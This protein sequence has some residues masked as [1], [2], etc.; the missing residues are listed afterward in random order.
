MTN[1]KPTSW[2][3]SKNPPIGNYGTIVDKRL[4]TITPQNTNGYVKLS[5]STNDPIVNALYYSIQTN[6]KVTYAI[7]DDTGV[8]LTVDGKPLKQFNNIQE[9]ASTYANYTNATTARIKDSLQLNLTQKTNDIIINNTTQASPYAKSPEKSGLDTSTD[10]NTDT[11]ANTTVDFSAISQINPDK[12]NP[13]FGNL[14][15]PTNIQ[16]N[17][18]DFIK[19]TVIKYITRKLDVSGPIGVLSDRRSPT[20]KEIKGNIILPIQ[21]SISDSNSVDWNGLGINPL[22]MELTNASLNLM[23]GSGKAY[24][25]N[26]IDKLSNTIKDQ[27][28]INSIKLY[29]AQKAAGVDGLL[30][31][32]TGSIVNP[33]LELLFNGPTLRPFNFSFRLSPRN[34][35]EA[36]TVRK[37]IRVFKQ[38]SAV[39]TASNGLFLTAPDV[40]EIKYVSRGNKGEENDHKSL[41]RIKTCAL[42]S[43][44]VD[45]TPDG[46]YMTFNDE[47]KTMTSYSIS[48]QFQELEPVTTRDYNSIPYDEIGY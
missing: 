19:F 22:E 5:T 42:K 32:V 9:I 43:V 47:A 15:Y 26:L 11:D 10:T 35:P 39:G 29:F 20:E 8:T 27:N 45:Y 13:N 12:D 3:L 1:N 30:S 44:N 23:S 31:R 48:L 7:G 28:A 6:G 40:F 16:N 18:Q 36:E 17:G 25:D 2:S 4:T 33:N 21:P 41:N 46:S 34:S 38:Y 14:I 24:V 37:I